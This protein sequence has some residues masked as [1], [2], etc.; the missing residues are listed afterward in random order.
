MLVGALQLLHVV[1]TKG[2]YH[3]CDDGGDALSDFVAAFLRG[4][5]GGSAATFFDLADEEFARRWELQQQT[6][7][8]MARVTS[9]KQMLRMR[10]L[11]DRGGW[12]ELLLVHIGES[13][14]HVATNMKQA[15]SEGADEDENE[16]SRTRSAAEHVASAFSLAPP[17]AEAAYDAL[18]AWATP[19]TAAHLLSMATNEAVNLVRPRLMVLLWR[20]ITRACFRDCTLDFLASKT[21]VDW[22]TFRPAIIAAGEVTL[23]VAP[24]V[25]RGAGIYY[26]QL[27]Q[28]AEPNRAGRKVAGP[29]SDDDDDEDEEELVGDVIPDLATWVV[30]ATQNMM[31][32]HVARPQLASDERLRD[33]FVA[34]AC[35]IEDIAEF[36]SVMAVIDYCTNNTPTFGAAGDKNALMQAG[37][38]LFLSPPIHSVFVHC[39]RRL[40]AINRAKAT[41]ALDGDSEH[42][43]EQFSTKARVKKKRP[44]RDDI[45]SA[46]SEM[47]RAVQDVTAPTKRGAALMTPDCV[48]AVA[49]LADT[50]GFY[51]SMGFRALV[52]PWLQPDP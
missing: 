49:E 25:T 11:A 30:F 21:R 48:S 24:R 52:K 17:P 34:L 4:A 13:P 35:S 43:H 23:E 33:A 8:T 47:Q 50:C 15:A 46:C 51:T 44:H 28:Q 42:E 10:A 5:C 27:T 32:L 19:V 1:L 45:A 29:N 20:A 39:G 26:F 36:P 2:F 7:K 9:A 16:T 31:W 6:T 40:A 37:T 41:G 12:A 3:R 14:E 38:R 18:Y 22:A